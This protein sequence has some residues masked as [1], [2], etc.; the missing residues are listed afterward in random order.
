MSADDLHVAEVITWTN[1]KSQKKG[2]EPLTRVLPLIHQAGAGPLRRQPLLQSH[3]RVGI[4]PGRR[5]AVISPA[6]PAKNTRRPG[7]ISAPG[8]NISKTPKKQGEVWVDVSSAI[9][10]GLA[11]ACGPGTSRFHPSR[12]RRYLPRYGHSPR[13]GRQTARQGPLSQPLRQSAMVAIHL[14]PSPR[15]RTAHS[16]QRRLRLGR[17]PNPVGYNRMYV[18]VDGDFTYEKWWQ[19]FRAG[20]WS[21]PT[22]R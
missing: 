16:A 3:G 15:V 7:R 14:F 10:L 8:Q 22:A 9:L 20:Q 2:T 12:P 1:D 5:G 4:A 11:F 18:H 19:S 13:N 6:R 17:G 21:L